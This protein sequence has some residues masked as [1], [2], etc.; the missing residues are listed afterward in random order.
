MK[1]TTKRICGLCGKDQTPLGKGISVINNPKGYSIGLI[2]DCCYKEAKRMI[3]KLAVT[4]GAYIV[5]GNY[6]CSPIGTPN[7]RSFD[8]L[9]KAIGE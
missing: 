3:D 2:G 6:K 8:G 7:V 4:W 1:D 5:D 9:K